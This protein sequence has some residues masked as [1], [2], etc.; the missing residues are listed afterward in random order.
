MRD[1]KYL[2]H[3][4]IHATIR[5]SGAHLRTLAAS[6]AGQMSLLGQYGLMGTILGRSF[7]MQQ[8]GTKKGGGR[9]EGRG[10][11]ACV[12]TAR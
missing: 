3:I 2:R 11:Q 12:K 7:A 8:S 10:R 1:A 5:G 4:A 9:G 6:A